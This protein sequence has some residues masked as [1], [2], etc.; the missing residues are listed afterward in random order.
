MYTQLPSHKP[1][2]R[3]PWALSLQKRQSMLVKG[4][5]KIA[6]FYEQPN[7][8]TF[9]YR[10]FNFCESIRFNSVKMEVSASFFHISDVSV[11]DWIAATANMLIVC[12]SGFSEDLL[13]LIT[14]FKDKN[15]VVIFDVDDLV[16]DPRLTFDILLALGQDA[17]DNKTLD[18]WY[19]YTSRMREAALLCDSITATNTYL[20]SI[21][22]KSLG[23]KADVISNSLNRDQLLVSH[24]I[25]EAKIRSNFTR[26]SRFTIGYFSGSPSHQRDF[27]LISNSLKILL[28]QR[29]NVDIIIAG[30]IELDSSLSAYSDRVRYEHFRDYLSLQNLIGTCELCIAPLV[31]STFT[32]C[33]SELKFF[34]SAAV[35]TACIATPTFS[36]KQAIHHRNTG[37]L[38]RSHEWIKILLQ[39]TENPSCLSSVAQKAQN[40][41]ISKYGP[42]AIFKQI[43]SA[44][45]LNSLF[46]S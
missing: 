38:C 5:F 11:F 20:A 45:Q 3:E 22:S 32:N 21:A 42:S 6:Y 44:Y 8:S 10:T 31:F 24:E 2:T 36:F 46:R 40:D 29:K 35:G 1:L 12:R 19:S 34:E 9:R 33:K 4:K 7:N 28:E 13:R 37:Y 14:L 27:Q 18:Y 43:V 17:S 16:V 25:Y 30:Y 26:D 41:A 39:I 15:K 23:K